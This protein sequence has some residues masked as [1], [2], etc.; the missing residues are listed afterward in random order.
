MIF[1]CSQVSNEQHTTFHTSLQWR[2]AIKCMLTLRSVFLSLNQC[3]DH[4]L[5]KKQ[6]WGNDE[7]KRD[8]IEKLEK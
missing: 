4:V 5:F 8:A 2:T 7:K 3:N 1:F 6:K